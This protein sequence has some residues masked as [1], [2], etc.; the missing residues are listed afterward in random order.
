MLGEKLQRFFMQEKSIKK[1]A[2]LNVMRT[3]LSLVFPLITFPYTSRVLGPA[4]IG[5]VSFAQSIITY[6]SMIAALG[7]SNYGIREAARLRNDIEKLTVF[8][9]EIFRINLI[10]MTVA[11]LLFAIALL[12][13]PK[14][15]SIARLLCVCSGTI[16]FTSIGFDW[17]YSALEDYAYI[18]VRSFIF[19][20]IS[21]VL[22]F[23]L[24]KS[25]D[26]Y[27]LY[28][29]IGVVSGAGSNICNFFHT[30]KYIRWKQKVQYNCIKHVKPIFTLFAM[31]V[32]ISVYT[33]LDTVMLG[34]ITDS[35]QVGYYTAATKI[36]KIILSVVTAVSTVLL[37]RLS[38]YAE[39][40]QSGR[41]E[42]LAEKGMKFL[43]IFA[44]PATVGLTLVSYPTMILF[45]GQQYV[46]AIPVMQVM[47]PIIL[48][49]SLSGLIGIQIFMPL[50]KEKYTLVSV[51]GGAV[52]NFTLNLLLIPRYGA[53]GAAIATVCAESVVTVTQLILA[54]HYFVW[55]NILIH[56]VQ[57]I[58]AV[59]CMGLA[60][61]FVMFFFSSYFFQLIV[62]VCAGIVVYFIVL[63]LLRNKFLFEILKI[64]S[65]L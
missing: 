53:M 3:G 23:V 50:R 30:R 31:S 10:S 54:R 4:S 57:C 8:T 38:F 11:Y 14:F 39:D 24:V 63:L 33:V 1:N 37:P 34:F 5:Q 58:V 12:C 16:F 59:I 61:Y 47:N 41:F 32:V 13:V 42:E 45:S 25:P 64:K 35:T 65:S 49:I 46:A 27:I 60:V 28:A 51:I 17:L 48:I 52:V 18:T 29:G 40:K 26:D 2:F 15:S 36:N 44:L 20:V 6:F 19:Q 9:K 21:V 55:K 62:G 56:S 43:I 7:I 22:L